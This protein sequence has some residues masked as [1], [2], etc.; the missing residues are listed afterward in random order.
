MAHRRKSGAE[1]PKGARALLKSL[2]LGSAAGTLLF[3][4]LLSALSLL[5]LRTGLSQKALPYLGIAA[6][7]LSALCAGFIGVR[8]IGKNGLVMGV[9]AVLPELLV[10]L[11]TVLFT[12]AALGLMTVVMAAAMLAASAGGGVLAVNTR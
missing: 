1:D 2:A 4:L 6:A 10:L 11:L 7:A 5:V 12:S 8:G 9:C 3:F